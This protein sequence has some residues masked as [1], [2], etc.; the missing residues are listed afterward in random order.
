[1]SFP[2]KNKNLRFHDL[3]R[4][5][6]GDCSF[7]GSTLTDSFTRFRWVQ[8]QIEHLGNQPT[9][10]LV[11][12]ALRELPPDL[13]STYASIMARIPRENQ[14]FAKEAMLWL[15]FASRP[16]RLTEVCETLA[17]TESDTTVD[18]SDRLLNANDLLRW[19]QGLITYHSRT[20]HITLSHSSVRAYLVSDHIKNTQSSFFSIDENAVD[21]LLFR[22]CLAY[23]MLTDFSS[24]YLP[25]YHEWKAFSRRWPLLDY[26]SNYWASHAHTLDAA[27]EPCDQASISRFCSTSKNKQGG[28]FGFW[29]Q[30]LCPRANIRV[31][32]TTQPLYYA[33]SF[34]LRAVVSS[35]ISADKDLDLEA[36]G[37]QHSGTAL[38]VACYRGHY[39][40]A[41][42]LL[43]AGATPYC[44]DE[45]QRSAL[46][47]ALCHGHADIAE[48]LR[49]SLRARTNPKGEAASKHIEE[50]SA[51]ARLYLGN[52]AH[53]KFDPPQKIDKSSVLHA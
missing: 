53:F 43:D 44:K 34:G 9:G 2:K 24:G 17:F 37:G 45:F 46:F 12:K 15:G 30:C 42:D 32:R 7:K 4:T 10:R 21:K 23:M 31:P 20:S 26:A 47:Y 50:A 39:G 41:K 33:A 1:M 19:C 36:V 13:N 52:P 22:K 11:D 8:C 5:N 3:W 6:Q 28:N 29:V 27:L 16:L 49:Q 40:V 18:P 38:Q 14:G 35:L 25:N 48:L 51:A